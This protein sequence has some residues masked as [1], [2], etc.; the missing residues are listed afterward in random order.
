M[1]NRRLAGALVVLCL[2]TTARGSA[3]ADDA[4]LFRVFLK[5]GSSLTSYGEFARVG[6][7]VVFSMPTSAS[8]NPPL[9]LVNIGADQIDWDKTNR[10]AS[11]A[12]ATHYLETQA[13][14]D[15][16][17]LS[18]DLAQTLNDV[19]LTT[20]SAKRLAIVERAR[21]TLAEWPANHFNYRSAEVRQMLTMLDDAI[22]DLRASSGGD[23]F[24]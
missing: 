5:D 9:H 22:S 21:K 19:A 17:V 20:D 4:T 10:Y 13:D 2:L 7:R 16:A 12:R 8:A 14:N 6:D 15:Y 23:K 11:S 24:A 18:N 1:C 3:A